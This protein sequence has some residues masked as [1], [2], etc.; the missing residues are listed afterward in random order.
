MNDITTGG[1]VAVDEA[2][3]FGKPLIV[4]GVK[5]A[6]MITP[7]GGLGDDRSVEIVCEFHP[8]RGSGFGRKG[9]S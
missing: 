8:T 4:A 7:A 1:E 2:I 5:P 3:L 9:A 6:A